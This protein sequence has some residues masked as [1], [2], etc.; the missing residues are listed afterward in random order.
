MASGIEHSCY[1]YEKYYRKSG[2]EDDETSVIYQNVLHNLKSK[3][4]GSSIAS[5]EIEKKDKAYENILDIEISDVG[6]EF[7]LLMEYATSR[8][9]ETSIETFKKRYEE[10]C[11]KLTELAMNTDLRVADVTA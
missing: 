3:I 9:E 1:P 10:I 2:L 5:V 4:C 6:D 8:Y 11:E 7:G